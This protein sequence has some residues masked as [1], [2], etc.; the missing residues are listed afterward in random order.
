[1]LQRD[2]AEAASPI[3]SRLVEELVGPETDV[4]AALHLDARGMRDL[5]AAGMTLGGHTRDHVWLDFV[6]PD[7]ARRQ[8]AASRAQ[9]ERL[10]PE[11]GWPFAYPFG[12]IPSD[13]G[14]LIEAAGFGAAFAATARDRTDPWRLGRVDAEILGPTPTTHPRFAP[15]GAARAPSAPS[16]PSAPTAASGTTAS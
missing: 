3:L 7:E 10:A 11:G 16:A 8:L 4:A 15:A 5:R 9:L 2:L 6:A 13:P 12:G 1:V 14:A